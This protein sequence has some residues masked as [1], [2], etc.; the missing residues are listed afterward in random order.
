MRYPPRRD[1]QRLFWRQIRAGCTLAEAS[2]CLGMNETTGLR[3]FH[4][5]GGMPPLS[6]VEPL[7]SRR[8]N[9]TEREKILA[10]INQELSIRAIAALIGRAPS[11]VS[12]ELALNLRQKYAPRPGR[13]AKGPATAWKYS[14]NAAQRRADANA[15]RPK[16][17]KLAGNERLREQVQDRL[18]KEH[19]PE[20]ISARL[21]AD[22]PDD[23]EMRVS[24]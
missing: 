12:R 10:G 23:L 1:F 16:R 5:A 19:S 3:W 21:K 2:A 17:A 8:L 20:Q 4:K 7:K 11:T 24:H 6:I 15:A 14:P 22:F 9:V 18:T 13:R